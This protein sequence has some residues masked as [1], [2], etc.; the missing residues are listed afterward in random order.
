MNKYYFTFLVW[1]LPAYFIFQCGYQIYTYV[2]IVSTYNDGT[3]YVAKV[4]DF[5]VK[6]IAAQTNGYVVL[7]FNTS[8]GET[9]ERQLSLPV[10]FAQ[11]IMDSEVIPIRYKEDSGKTIVMMPVFE[12]QKKVIR[13]NIAVTTIGLIATLILSFFASRYALRKLKTGDEKLEIERIDE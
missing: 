1:L 10:Q 8:D 12:L 13:V 4:T 6:Q 11:V 3:S 9:I 2:G 7:E 5:D